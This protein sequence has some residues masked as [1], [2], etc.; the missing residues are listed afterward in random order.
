[1][2]LT[3]A[4]LNVVLVAVFVFFEPRAA[5]VVT[6]MFIQELVLFFVMAY[7]IVAQLGLRDPKVYPYTRI[8]RLCL[9]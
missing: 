2:I 6:E 1:L 8:P 5:G 7:L 3:Q 4:Y 9:A